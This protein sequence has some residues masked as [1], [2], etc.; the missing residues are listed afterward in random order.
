MEE[1]CPLTATVGFPSEA[2]DGNGSVVTPLEHKGGRGTTEHKLST[3]LVLV[4]YLC[5][6]ESQASQHRVRI[7][8]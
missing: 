7:E 1:A 2:W 4:S 6:H 8:P 3:G 5:Y